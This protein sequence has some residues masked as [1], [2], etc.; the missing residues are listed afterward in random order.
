MPPSLLVR[1]GVSRSAPGSSVEPAPPDPQPGIGVAVTDVWAVRQAE[2]GPSRPGFEV[3]GRTKGALVVVPVIGS[4]NSVKAVVPALAGPAP[5]S[6]TPPPASATDAKILINEFA[7]L[8]R[9]ISASRSPQLER[10]ARRRS[11]VPTFRSPRVAIFAAS[12]ITVSA[13]SVPFFG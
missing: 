13:T 8:R 1:L 5:M 6:A 12:A 7:R 11:I 2:L 10:P 9:I 3:A 4:E